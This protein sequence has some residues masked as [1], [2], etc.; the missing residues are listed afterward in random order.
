LGTLRENFLGAKLM[1]FIK[2]APAAWL[3]MIDG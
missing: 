2:L 1:H 3:L